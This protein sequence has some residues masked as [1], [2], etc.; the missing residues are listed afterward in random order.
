VAV[1]ALASLTEGYDPGAFFDE[2]V[3]APGVPRPHYR[4]LHEQLARMTRVELEDRQR[5]A[6]PDGLAGRDAS[7]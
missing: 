4:R 7:Q 2:M 6:E 1:D 3:A 5:H